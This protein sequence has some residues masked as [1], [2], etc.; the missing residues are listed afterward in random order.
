MYRV[1]EQKSELKRTLGLAEA[2][3]FGVG[4]ILGAGIYAVVGE[5]AG[6]S[7]NMIWLSFLIA[8]V[9]AL[10]SALSYAEIS[11][12]FPNAGGEYVYTKKGF[13]KIAVVIGLLV[14]FTGIMSGATVA[15]G[16]AGYFSEL[17]GLNTMLAALGIVA[18]VAIVNVSGIRQSSLVNIIFTVIEF[19][20][21]VL[22]VYAAAPSIGSIDYFEVPPD[23]FN[24]V[25]L[26]AALSYFAFVGFE[27]IVKLSE[28]TKKPE[29]NIPR[30]LFIA[31]TIVI[32]VY[33]VVSVCAVSAMN[34]KQLGETKNPLAAIV[35]NRLGGIGVTVVS[36][37]ALFATTNTILS[38]MLGSSRV[39]ME[40]GRDHELIKRF[41][42][43]SRVTKTP[44]VAL[45]LIA[46]LMAA[47]SLI[48]RLEVL[49]LIANFFV[50]T[51]FIT[52]NLLVIKLRVTDKNLNRPYKVPLSIS[53]V[54]VTAVIAVLLTLV[55]FG[56]S[57]YGVAI[58]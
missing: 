19:S 6:A 25:L 51:A 38:N 32:V 45:I 16:F 13:P 39:L 49:A 41:A 8:S 53:N 17:V 55:L 22:V 24:G 35:E 52:V 27:E 48:G 26:G 34:W 4:S 18:L 47:L 3:F 5:V 54:P 21:L 1:P 46:C 33:L 12:M 29:K 2:T 10:L 50:F 43:V 37:I 31:I 56:Y 15:V 28:E 58:S 57:I 23:G 44:V 11:S 30:A 40:M 9:T 42:T 36:V 14:S 7:G 20:G